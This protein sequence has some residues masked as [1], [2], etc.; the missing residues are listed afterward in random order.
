M[1]T[2]RRTALLALAA[3]GT[4]PMVLAATRVL[5]QNAAPTDGGEYAMQTLMAGSFALETSRIAAEKA[6]DPL[7]KQFAELEVAEQTTIAEI[8]TSTGVTPP[9]LPAER[10]QMIADMQAMET[11]AEFDAAYIEGQIAGHQELLAIQQTISGVSELSVE[12]ITA[13]LAEQAITSHL[14]MLEHIQLHVA[15]TT[16]A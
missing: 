10:Q 2:T 16:P 8:L 5:A 14:A 6:M 9:A 13:R 4:T 12:V 7:V 3:V 15:G 1:D 11:N